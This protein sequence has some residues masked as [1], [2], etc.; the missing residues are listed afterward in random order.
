MS[1][2]HRGRSAISVSVS[3]E[4]RSDRL[5]LPVG[6]LNLE[7][8]LKQHNVDLTV[9]ESTLLFKQG[10]ESPH[11]RSARHYLFV[12]EEA[13]L[14]EFGCEDFVLVGGERF[15]SLELGKH[16]PGRMRHQSHGQRHAGDSLLVGVR[17]SRL[18]CDL[19]P[20]HRLG[21]SAEMIHRC[22]VEEPE[23]LPSRNDL[24]ETTKPIHK[25]SRKRV[26]TIRHTA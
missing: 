20:G 6:T 7:C 18:C 4:S 8:V 11:D 9:L 1:A 17:A 24:A 3:F 15:E 12:G 16:G 22:V 14:T 21:V 25:I 13:E 5:H 26:V 19:Y 10:T 23:L 2:H